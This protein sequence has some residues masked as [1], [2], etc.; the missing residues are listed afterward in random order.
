MHA[1]NSVSLTQNLKLVP[2]IVQ[3]IRYINATSCVTFCV[4]Y[5]VEY[6]DIFNIFQIVQT[7]Y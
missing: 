4:H 6:V 2:V 3:S 1:T 7:F 5:V